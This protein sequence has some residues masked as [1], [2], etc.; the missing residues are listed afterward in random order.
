MATNIHWLDGPWR[1]RLG[2][3][4]R[5]RG[6]DWLRDEMESWRRAGADG[7]LSLLTREEERE[8]ALESESNAAMANRLAFMSFPIPDRQVPASE[9][10]VAKLLE[11]LDAKLNSGKSVVVH[12]R[13]GIGRTGLVAASLLIT[14]GWDPENAIK[15]VSAARGVAVPETVEQLRWIEDFGAKLAAAR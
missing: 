14:K 6:G 12:C 10:N 4:A 2:L 5:P 1:G 9:S 7:I 15:H 8:L 11:E 3:A 13:Q